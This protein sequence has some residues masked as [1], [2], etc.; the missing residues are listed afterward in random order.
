MATADGP[1]GLSIPGPVSRIRIASVVGA[2]EGALRE[3]GRTHWGVDPEFARVVDGTAGLVC[4]YRE[5]ARLGVDRW[6]AMLGARARSRQD[7]LVV[8][9]GTALTVDLVDAQGRHRGGY[10]V[11]GYS[12]MSSSLGAGTWGVRPDASRIPSCAPGTTTAEAVANG[13]LLAMLGVVEHG[14][15]ELNAPEVMV[16][17]GEGAL[18][19]PHLVRRVP[20]RETPAL[21]MEGLEVALPDREQ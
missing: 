16:T 6:L 11:P 13:C 10:I 20:V 3:W 12:T 9:C 19:V 15:A 5:P 2:L 8:S 17:G 21:V 1:A 7:L 14:L 18:L 4:G